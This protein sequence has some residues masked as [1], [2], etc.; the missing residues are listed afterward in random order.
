MRITLPGSYNVADLFYTLHE[1]FILKCILL[2]K[3]YFSFSSFVFKWQPVK[4]TL[5]LQNLHCSLCE[6]YF[7]FGFKCITNGAYFSL[8]TATVAYVLIHKVKNAVIFLTNF[9]ICVLAEFTPDFARW[10]EPLTSE[11]L[12]P[13][14]LQTHMETH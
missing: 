13:A 8:P 6:I 5:G 10:S 1:Y 11:R 7:C 14:V 12:F 9:H 3:V 4:T 2:L